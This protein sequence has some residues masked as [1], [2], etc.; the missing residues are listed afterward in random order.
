MINPKPHPETSKQATKA[1]PAKSNMP[2]LDRSGPDSTDGMNRQPI[3]YLVPISIAQANHALGEWA[4][5][6]GAFRRPNGFAWAHGLYEHNRLVAV[7]ITSALVN[8]VAVGGFSRADAGELARL[9]AS[10]PDL[11]RVML[12]LWREA[13]WPG[14]AK[15]RG[16]EWA[17]SYQDEDV[18]H[19]G[20]YRF[21][22]WRRAARSHSGVD[23]RTGR[24]GRNK[25]VWCW[26]PN[27]AVLL[28]RAE[29][30]HIPAQRAPRAANDDD[31]GAAIA[32]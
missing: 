23:R 19:G 25:V 8:R 27:R 13:V 2:A 26:H 11:C 10:R 15:A 17:I 29:A 1:I 32:A 18:H 4:H 24:P 28:K 6:M 9:C 14:I 7:T 16:W 12:R 20:T 30:A 21:D 31:G 22:G 3:V 5:K